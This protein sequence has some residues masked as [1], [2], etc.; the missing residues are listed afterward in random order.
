[1]PKVL[2]TELKNNPKYSNVVTNHFINNL[3]LS[4][5]LHDIGKVGI[6]DA[7]LRKTRPLHQRRTY[8]DATTYATW[9]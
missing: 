4:A 9:T 1:M 8:G 5:V 3:A 7:I 6:E 2:A